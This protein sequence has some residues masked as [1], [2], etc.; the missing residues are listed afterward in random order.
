[1]SKKIALVT[2]GA[3]FIGS[4]LCEALLR[5]GMRVIAIDNFS[6]GHVRNI[7]PYL[8][9]PD[10]QFLRLDINKPFDITEFAELEGFQV[11][12]IGIAEIY[13][14]AS[15]TSIRNFKEHCVQTLLTNSVGTHHILELASQFKSSVL[16][17]SSGVVYGGVQDG[18]G[19]FS[20]GDIGLLDHLTPRAC[21]D[22]SKKFAETMLDTYARNRDL[23]VK[24]ARIFRSFGPRMPIFDGHQIAD[25][26][27]AALDNQEVIVHGRENEETSLL[28]VS[29]IADALIR[30]M[31]AKK[32]IGP[33]NIGSDQSITLKAV[34]ELVIQMTE[35]QS[36]IKMEGPIDGAME[37]GLPDITKAKEELGWLPLTSIEDGLQ[38]TIDYVRA[39]KI[40]LNSD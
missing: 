28:Y 30:L 29:D 1:M 15:P 37:T 2:G 3:G 26:V 17:G 25:Y 22:E 31:R 20:E 12:H 16:L 24:I 38:K 32:G 40:L 6:T 19:V 10:F 23:D 33:V 34:A 36:T 39:N 4:F 21:Y 7:E 9:N 18:K 5:D 13:H 8:S 35:S 27:M 11:E 14:L